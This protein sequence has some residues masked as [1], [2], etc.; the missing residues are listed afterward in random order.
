VSALPAAP[1][2]AS[3]SA[4]AAPV[5]A[6]PFGAEWGRL[7]RL[8]VRNRTALAGLVLVG[9]L[10]FAGVAGPWIAP[11]DPDQRFVSEQPPSGE[12][13]FGTD[14]LGRD[15]FSGVLHGARITLMV[16]FI[17][18]G[19]ALSVGLTLGAVSGYVGGW[20]DSILQRFVDVMMS[21]PGILL[22]ILIVAV[23]DR[24]SLGMAMIAVGIVG[25]PAYTRVVRATV[26]QQ[27]ELDYVAAAR[28]IGASP[29]RIVTRGILPN[30]M[31]PVVVQATL[32]FAA[33]ILEAAGLSFLGLGAQPPTK[34]WGLM[35]K[36]GWDT[37]RSAPWIMTFP[38][39]FIFLAVLSLN[40]LGDGLRDVLD[41]RD[42]GSR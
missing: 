41:P 33:A 30:I 1:P 8:L 4:T 15:L 35:V 16:G 19:I 11:H 31:G 42:R 24:P 21:F 36:A 29:L 2:P 13:W 20:F 5:A 17:S 10:A 38:G 12:H 22:A 18:V 9:L 39:L 28:A 3:A 14:G 37:W 34:E 23:T 27:A 32:G 25:I 26:M 6:R 7:A 40:L